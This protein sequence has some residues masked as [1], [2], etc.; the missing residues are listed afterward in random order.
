LIR[1]DRLYIYF[2]NIGVRSFVLNGA[3]V[4]SST[5]WILRP[6]RTEPGKHR[7]SKRLALIVAWPLE[8]FAAGRHPHKAWGLRHSLLPSD[9]SIPGGGGCFCVEP[10]LHHG[11]ALG[12]LWGLLEDFSVACNAFDEHC[13]PG[14]PLWPPQRVDSASLGV[15][16]QLSM[17]CQLFT[18]HTSP[19]GPIARS[20]CI[21]SP[22]PT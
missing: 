21:C 13:A 10:T 2:N 18:T 19:A 20:V 15:P 14:S 3:P 6:W 5:S 7:V 4:K 12:E 8:L 11:N 1:R 16:K 17:S 9:P 22:P